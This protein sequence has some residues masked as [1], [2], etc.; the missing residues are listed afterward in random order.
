MKMVHVL[1]GAVVLAG[2]AAIFGGG[3]R[4]K[5]TPTPETTPR[6]QQGAIPALPGESDPSGAAATVIEG[7]ALEVLDVPSYTYIR[8]GESGSDGT[9]TAVA[10][11]QV[12]VGDK[13]KVRSETLMTD[14]E[15]KT[16]KRKFPS[17]HFGSL[18][19]G[20]GASA[21][22]GAMPPGHPPTGAGTAAAAAPGEMP[23][24]H[25]ATGAPATGEAPAGH[26]PM[27]GSGAPVGA[28]PAGD[29]VIPK[30]EKA[31]GPLGRR[32]AEIFAQKKELAGKKVRVRG[33]VVKATNGIM[34]KNFVHLRDGSGS[35]KSLD[36]DLSVTTTED[37]PKGKTVLLEGTLV[38]DKD[39]GAGYKY[40]A[41]LED[42]KSVE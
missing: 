20:Q 22:G 33:V 5:A 31:A 37:L 2:A 10:T 9:W 12:K 15:S 25:P 11:A 7:Q 18:D 34:G 41:L 35:E 42:A 3:F 38:L 17:I 39:L 6:A 36:H 13:V 16:L 14:F 23:P 4:S 8:I 28:A 19:N 29:V 40:D 26:P 24:G 30:L 27:A 1:T 21:A 32:I